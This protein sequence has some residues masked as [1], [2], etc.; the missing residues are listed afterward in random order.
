MA[1]AIPGTSSQTALSEGEPVNI[2]DISELKESMALTP[3]TINII[4]ATNSAT[5]MI[6]FISNTPYMLRLKR[7]PAADDTQKD[8]DDKVSCPK[9]GGGLSGGEFTVECV[10]IL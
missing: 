5:D 6:L 10:V 9:T 8:H 2:R 3:Q 7:F 1:A 4:P